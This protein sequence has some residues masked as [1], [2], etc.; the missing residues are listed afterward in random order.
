[1]PMESKASSEK[2]H[3]YGGRQCMACGGKACSI[4]YEQLRDMVEKKAM[5]K[6]APAYADGG[7]ISTQPSPTPKKVDKDGYDSMGNKVKKDTS[8]IDSVNHALGNYAD[9]GEVEESGDDH[10][11]VMDQ[12]ADECME[13]LKSGDKAGFKSAMHA[14]MADFMSKM[15]K[16][17]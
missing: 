8:A 5:V 7:M 15:G 1:M 13:A 11:M 2:K 6:P 14:M 4:S 10:E 3:A 16:E 9:G 17:D 12:C